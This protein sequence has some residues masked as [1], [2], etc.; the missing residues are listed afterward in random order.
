[1]RQQLRRPV[2]QRR[3]RR[4]R[5]LANRPVQHLARL[6]KQLRRLRVQPLVLLQRLQA[7]QPVSLLVRQPLLK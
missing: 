5:P 7:K 6:V 3:H 4:V 2:K 1:M